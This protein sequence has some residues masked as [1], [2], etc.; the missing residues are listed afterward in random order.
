MK[1]TLALLVALFALA[2]PAAA[3]A[4][5]NEGPGTVTIAP[6][7]LE[8]PPA[9]VGAEG[10]RLAVDI[11]YE[12]DGEAA[13]DKLT[14]LGEEA[15]EFASNGSD[16]DVLTSGQHCTAWFALK[17]TSLGEKQATLEVRFQ[18]DRPAETRPIFGAAVAPS[19]SFD[20]AS[21]DFGPVWAGRGGY[22]YLQLQ[23]TGAAPVNLESLWIQGADP[24]NFSIGDNG[25][26]GPS[27]AI[28][29]PGATCSVQVNFQPWDL[30]PYEATFVA[31][32]NG[33]EF[34]AGLSG[35]GGS[36]ELVPDSNPLDFGFLTVGEHSA[37][38][39][40]TLSNE[41][42]LPGSFFIAIVAGGDT[43]S[44]ELLSEDCSG[45]GI[46]PGQSCSVQLRFK[47][48]SAGPKTARLAM[49]GESDGGSMV[50]LEGLAAPAA[51]E[52]SSASLDLGDQQ[53]GTRGSARTVWLS[54][55]GAAAASV[56]RIDLTGADTDQFVLAGDEC[57]D[58]TLE[59]GA[60]CALRVRFAP[61]S[62]G[63][64]AATLRV[65]GGFG[66][67]RAALSGTGTPAP[68]AAAS[69][70]DALPASTAVAASKPRPRRFAHN[71]TIHAPKGA[72]K[73]KRAKA[74][75]GRS[76]R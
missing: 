56:D 76:A 21:L 4:A 61:D 50:F 46:E 54:N 52:L 70:S 18:G 44:F 17:P 22:S 24:G 62:A 43:G 3:V 28:M 7:P 25:C 31:R 69:A 40:V 12:G 6:T 5:P 60:S 39:T 75:A 15:G 72:K 64:K 1:T 49:F 51:I 47:P 65:R 57:S 11:S 14:L 42:N 66:V 33:V 74:R 20:P 23:N 53:A 27:G 2:L 48:T 41:G 16:C 34:S 8:V 13:I 32:A 26:I 36:A 45:R 19:L 9:T 55:E 63:P 35:E 58:T 67:R 59:P 73:A 71:A 10:E 30:R 68:A 37:V 29:N 38:R